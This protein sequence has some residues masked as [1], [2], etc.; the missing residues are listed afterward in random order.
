MRPR[1][2][3]H[4]EA[5]FIWTR[6]LICVSWSI[7]TKEADSQSFNGITALT[8]KDH[9]FK[10]SNIDVTFS[11]TTNTANV[12][13]CSGLVGGKL[14][15]LVFD[16]VL[17][18]Q[19]KFPFSLFIHK[20]C[21]LLFNVFFL[22]NTFWN[23]RGSKKAHSCNW[24]STQSLVFIVLGTSLFHKDTY[25]ITIGTSHL[26]RRTLTQAPAQSFYNMREAHD[27]ALPVFTLAVWLFFDK[28]A[29]DKGVVPFSWSGSHLV[30][31]LA[32]FCWLAGQ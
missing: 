3:R 17:S 14:D 24:F 10:Q 9:S 25:A 28:C 23:H 31:L 8:V 7:A 12:R 6:V 11:R 26:P 29:A 22:R 20:I 1:Y 19:E 30:G 4:K 27:G 5:V 13:V 2:K 21:C 15:N 16:Q 32:C 18:W